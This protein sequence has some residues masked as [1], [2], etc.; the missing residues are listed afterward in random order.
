MFL[1]REFFL[2]GGQI[3]EF[4]HRVLLQHKDP[5]GMMLLRHKKRT[6][7]LFTDWVSMIKAG[8]RKAA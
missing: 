1:N 7:L 2:T 5:E 6:Y 8:S 3:R 4:F